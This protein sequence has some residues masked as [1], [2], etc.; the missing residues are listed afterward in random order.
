MK[1]FMG[2]GVASGSSQPGFGLSR[3][4]LDFKLVTVEVDFINSSLRG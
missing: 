1:L 3:L 2:G 4:D